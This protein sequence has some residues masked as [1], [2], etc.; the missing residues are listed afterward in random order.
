MGLSPGQRV[1][2][3]VV[4]R[5][6]GQG[7]MADVWL[8]RHV[9]LGSLCA[10]KVPVMAPDATERLIREGRAQAA[11][12]HPNV[13]PV[14]D[15]LTV[16]GTPAL[17]LPYVAGP[18]LEQLLGERRLEIPEVV[19]LLVGM[20]RGL[21]HAHATGVVHGDVKPANVLLQVAHDG[22]VPRIA[23]FGGGPVDGRGYGT[24]A[25]AAPE[26]LAHPETADPRHDLF[27]LGVM[28]LEMVL[29]RRPSRAELAAPL[30]VPGLPEGVERLIRTLLAPAPEGRGSA[31]GAVRLLEGQP[32][33]SLDPA[34][35]LA[36]WVLERV[37]ESTYDAVTPS[38]HNLPGGLPE[39]LGRDR[40][41]AELRARLES[42]RLVV[43]V[44]HGGIGKTRLAL[45]VAEAWHAAGS[46]NVWLCRA[47]GIQTTGALVAAMGAVLGL[48]LGSDPRGQ[49]SASLWG[50]GAALF[51][52]DAVEEVDGVE[53]LLQTWLADAPEAR[54]LVTSRVSVRTTGGAVVPVEP[55]SEPSA[56]E[57]FVERA[58]GAHP[59]FVVAPT[60]PALGRLLERLDGVP[61][62]V[63]LAA[64]QVGLYGLDDLATRLES[65]LDVL[66]T[67]RGDVPERQ[68]TL[69]AALEG[70]WALLEPAERDALVQLTVFASPCTLA[71]AD[72]VLDVAGRVDEALLGLVDKGLLRVEAGARP[73]FG[74]RSLVRTFVAARGTP[75]LAVRERHRGWFASLR[76]PTVA[77]LEDLAEAVNYAVSSGHTAN[78]STLALLAWQVYEGH[79]PPARG[80]LVLEH[81]LTVSDDPDLRAAAAEANRRAGHGARADQ[82]L[83]VLAAADDPRAYV[84]RGELRRIQGALDEAMASYKRALESPAPPSVHG[85]A[86]IGIGNVYV[87]L[88]E[89]DEARRSY[90]RADPYFDVGSQRAAAL[91]SN[92]GTLAL[93]AGD[94]VEAEQYLLESVEMYRLR[95]EPL[96]AAISQANLPT[97]YKRRGQLQRARATAAEAAAVFKSQGDRRHLAVISVNMASMAT[98]LGEFDVTA[99]C[100]A[101]ARAGFAA[102]SDAY[103]LAVVLG[104]EGVLNFLRGNLPEGRRCL[105]EA[106]REH[107]RLG[108]RH[109]VASW[110][111]H[112]VPILL[113][114]GER[115]LAEASAMAALDAFMEVED[116]EEA[117]R[118][119]TRLGAMRGVDGGEAWESALAL[120]PGDPLVEAI[121]RHGRARLA[122]D[123]GD[124]DAAEH[125]LSEGERHLRKV[126]DRIV[127]L[128]VLLDRAELLERLG[129]A[130][131]ADAA[132]FEAET[133]HHQMGLGAACPISI[134]LR[135]AS[136]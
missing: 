11:L 69:L 130:D 47:E 60:D 128:E 36:C 19:A 114:L 98:D 96:L 62:A 3:Y 81:A 111:S 18:N 110:R 13:L 119:W 59:P 126:T 2:R 108:F 103:G 4:L 33:A 30:D 89:L 135:G 124:R 121:A 58:A 95:G 64:A 49:V 131:A 22:L 15:V 35:D 74:M 78:A 66:H 23:D 26:Q 123:G 104:N 120:A 1:D 41:H 76:K 132:M 52:L 6:L 44:G 118:A 48:Q 79:G 42:H 90:A 7:G 136:H 102:A 25:Y 91:R 86:E 107:Q 87:S 65:T 117:A 31:S 93:V 77:D 14:R 27:A 63:E 67:R 50:Q 37:P 9:V 10:L 105:E 8:V 72:V 24:A 56:A 57:L 21:A 116:T 94:L 88:G 12:E 70:S 46:G 99:V 127:V 100:L 112:L 68:R 85:R 32:T 28:A 122:L 115:D 129:R 75:S 125:D 80:A 55:L 109:A 45:A 39:C 17:L 16:Q 71:A 133:L 97:I 106:I 54:F 29:G 92:R 5:T 20:A 53:A 38:D 34:S 84:L 43:L 101:D 61:L 40:E 82:H 51:V 73:R 113:G 134:R 83:D